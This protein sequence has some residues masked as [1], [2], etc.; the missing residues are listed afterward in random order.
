MGAKEPLQER[1]GRL[2]KLVD[3]LPGTPETARRLAAAARH[4]ESNE[5]LVPD[6]PAHVEVRDGWAV[7]VPDRPIPPLTVEETRAATDRVR[8]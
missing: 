1:K 4:L 3:S 2:H 8:R 7:I 5:D 6:V